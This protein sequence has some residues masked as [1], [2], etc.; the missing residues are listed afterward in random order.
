M[1]GD[2]GAYEHGSEKVGFADNGPVTPSQH[3]DDGAGSPN[4]IDVEG[5][6]QAK[7]HHGPETNQDTRIT[8][9]EGL[10]RLRDQQP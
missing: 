7:S 9:A 10:K 1:S 6:Q 4:E 5:R 3:P 8:E 2:G